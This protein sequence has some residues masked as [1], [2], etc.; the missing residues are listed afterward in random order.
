MSEPETLPPAPAETSPTPETAPAAT[1]EAAPAP[2]AA[3]TPATQPA[4]KPADKPADKRKPKRPQGGGGTPRRRMIEPI[5]GMDG[6]FKFGVGPKINE[7]DAEIAGELEAA[8]GG[9]GDI[10]G[11]ETSRQVRAEAAAT[12]EQ[13]RKKGKVHSIHG[14]DVFIDVPGGRSQGVANFLE[15]QGYDKVANI[16]GGIDAWARERDPAVPRY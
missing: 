14:P 10:L 6:D 11:G 12:T 2:A 3:S 16:A 7:L 1:A 5:P 15:R 8:L 9:I 4:A 13:G